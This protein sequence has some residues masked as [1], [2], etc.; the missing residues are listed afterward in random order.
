MRRYVSR[1]E[2]D[3]NHLLKLIFCGQ[4]NI[5]LRGR[6]DSGPMDVDET[7]DGEGNFRRLLRYRIE[8]GDTELREQIVSA[9]RNACY[10]YGDIQ[11]QLISGVGAEIKEKIINRVKE[12][13]FYTIMADETTDISSTEQLSVCLRYYHKESNTI[14]EDFIS[15]I[16][17]LEHEYGEKNKEECP[18]IIEPSTPKTIEEYLESCYEEN[19]TTYT[20]EEPRLTGNIIGKAIISEIETKWFISRSCNRTKL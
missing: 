16:E 7:K 5:A 15:F 4:N 17:V 18:V 10:T 6:D 1:I 14:K 19:E 8:S 3:L 13:G 12:S 2:S 20:L 9:P 11:N